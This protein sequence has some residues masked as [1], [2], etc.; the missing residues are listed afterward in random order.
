MQMLSV[1]SEVF[2]TSIKVL[3]VLVNT[4]AGYKG[5]QELLNQFEE[6]ENLNVTELVSGHDHFLVGLAQ[7]PEPLTMNAAI[8]CFLKP[9][10]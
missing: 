3:N 10:Q 5:S 7:E 8:S 1:D 9:P 4:C 2:T 6:T